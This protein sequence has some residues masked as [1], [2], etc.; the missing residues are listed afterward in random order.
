LTN[1]LINVNFSYGFVLDENNQ[2]NS[3]EFRV[4][5]GTNPKEQINL[6]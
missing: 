5:I 1:N 2:Y 6:A 3:L 4:I